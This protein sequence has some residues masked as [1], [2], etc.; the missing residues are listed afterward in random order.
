MVHPGQ[1]IHA[2]RRRGH[3]IRGVPIA[4]GESAI[5]RILG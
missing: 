3:N 1:E 4:A 5:C 2:H